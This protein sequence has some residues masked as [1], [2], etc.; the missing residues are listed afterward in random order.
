M[1]RLFLGERPS[2]YTKFSLIESMIRIIEH[3]SFEYMQG[4]Y[5]SENLWMDEDRRFINLHA[6]LYASSCF[7][8]CIGDVHRTI[9]H[10]NSIR[11]RQTIFPEA[12]N[13][14][15]RSLPIYKASLRDQIRDLRRLIQHKE[16]RILVGEIVEGEAFMA[17]LTGPEI[18][19]SDNNTLKILDRIELGAHSIRCATLSQALIQLRECADVLVIHEYDSP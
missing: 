19:T 10:V 17:N 14:L 11:G 2:A 7:E 18:L 8:N 3:A 6:H 15:P 16:D 13:I 1:R 5:V 12:R 9:C 4:K